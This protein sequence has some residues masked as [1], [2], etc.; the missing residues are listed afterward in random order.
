MM[1]GRFKE[2]LMAEVDVRTQS[3]VSQAEMKAWNQHDTLWMLSLFGTAIGAGVLFLPINA[4]SGGFLPLLIITVL[5]FPMTY[6]SH[7]TMSRFVLSASDPGHD[8]TDVSKEHF[9]GGIGG[10]V[11]FLYFFAIFPILLMYSVAITNTFE[12]F[13]INQLEMPPISRSLIA[14]VL[15]AGLLVII[16]V[17]QQMVVKAMSALVYPFVASL[18]VL[19]VY[20]IPHWNFGFWKGIMIIQSPDKSVA[21]S[22]GYSLWFLIPLMVFS[23]NHSPII[24]AFSM[25]QRKQYGVH[26][27]EKCGVILKNSHLMMI[28]MVMFFV[29]SCVLSLT[30]EDLAQARHDNITILSYLANHFD[31]PVIAYAAPLIAFIAIS[32]SFLGHFLGAREGLQGVLNRFT[33][34]KSGASKGFNAIDIA[35]V[36]VCWIVATLNPSILGMIETLGGPIIAVILF[37]MPVYA[38]YRVERLKQYQNPLRDGFIALIGVIAFST[39]IY[40]L[41]S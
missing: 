35:M 19:S 20:M 37:I 15:L 10:L 6:F 11:T 14:G 26:A 40:S 7:R 28:G 16:T 8:I 24:S 21:M 5:A 31:T 30:P 18:L 23:F 41:F 17:G 38:L 3:P 36:L 39:Q 4:G 27:D 1:V 9:G 33:V 2:Y 32:K 25:V 13:W 34:K 22:L 12:S 29:F